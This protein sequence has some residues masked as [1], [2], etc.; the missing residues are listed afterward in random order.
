LAPIVLAGEAFAGAG[1]QSQ[2]Y[3]LVN[4]GV[5]FGL[6]TGPSTVR[7]DFTL[8]NACIKAY[9][10]FLSRIKTNAFDPGMGRTLIARVSTDF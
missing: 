5:G 6:L 4:F 2:G 7:F 3:T 10:D 8:R 1:Y 9:A